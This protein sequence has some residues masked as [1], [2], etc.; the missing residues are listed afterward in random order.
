[1]ADKLQ[2]LEHEHAA[3][4]Q[5]LETA[6][7]AVVQRLQEGLKDAKTKYIALQWH[8]S[9]ALAKAERRKAELQVGVLCVLV[10]PVCVLHISQTHAYLNPTPPCP[11]LP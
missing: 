6:H 4:T 11:A 3:A 10:C 5:A 2:Q 1:M 9:G 7:R 8:S